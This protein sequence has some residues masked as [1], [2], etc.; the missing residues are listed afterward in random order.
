MCVRENVYGGLGYHFG[1]PYTKESN[2]LGSVLGSPYF[3]K[4]SYVYVDG[5]GDLW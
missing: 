5:Y 1:G 4:L 3:G 2:T